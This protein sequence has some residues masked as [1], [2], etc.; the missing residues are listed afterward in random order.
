MKTNIPKT[1]RLAPLVLLLVLLP[2]W[3]AQAQSPFAGLEPLFTTPKSYVAYFVEKAPAIDGNLDD[4]AWQAV[5]WSENFVDIEGNA[6]P[7]PAFDTRMKM[8]WN[9]T[10][11]FIAAEMKDPHVWATFKQHDAVIYHDNDF[12][13]FI[14]PENTAHQYYEIEVNALNTVFDLFLPKPYR[15]GGGAMIPWDLHR[16]QTAVQVQGTLNNP[17]DTDR[18]WTVEMAIPFRS[19]TIGNDTKVPADGSFWRINFSRVHWDTDIRDGNYVKRK[20]SKGRPLPEYNWVW[21]PQGL[22][23]M[24]YPERWGYLQFTRQQAGG[25]AVNFT[26]PYAEKQKNYLWLVYYRQKKYYEQ[27]R[28]YA[29]SLAML[30]FRKNDKIMVDN[31]LNDLQLE[32]TKRQFMAT[33]QGPDETLWSI[34]QEGLIQKLTNSL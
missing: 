30:G 33:I 14:D 9:D 16:L 28:Q 11:L 26:L 2:L 25:T 22:V 13:V 15:N 1:Q 3:S 20:D 4:E 24:H 5:A 12:E 17:A 29:S 18:G 31:Q 21:S 8:T 32:A 19:V 7:A 34:N 10:H 6:K 27:H 23:N